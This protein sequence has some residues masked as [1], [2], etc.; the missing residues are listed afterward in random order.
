V[1]SGRLRRFCPEALPSQPD[2]AS[3]AG[4][5][6]SISRFGRGRPDALPLPAVASRTTVEAV[7]ESS[8]QLL[9]GSSPQRAE[10]VTWFAVEALAPSTASRVGFTATLCITGA[11]AMLSRIHP[12]RC[13]GYRLRA[14]KGMLRNRGYRALHVSVYVRHIRNVCALL[15]MVVFRRWLIVVLFTVVLLTLTRST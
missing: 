15:T 9:D 12:H 11:D 4:R 6:L 2:C 14:G 13:P 7:E 5:K 1:S 8:L 3:A 10:A